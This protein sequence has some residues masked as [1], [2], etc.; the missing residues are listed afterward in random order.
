MLQVEDDGGR[1]TAS[2]SMFEM[3]QLLRPKVAVKFVSLNLDLEAN[4]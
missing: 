1:F 4:I 2:L 3:G